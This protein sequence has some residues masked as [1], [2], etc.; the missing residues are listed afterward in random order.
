MIDSELRTI[1]ERVRRG[2]AVLSTK[3]YVD[4]DPANVMSVEEALDAIGN[5]TMQAME[6]VAAATDLKWARA[7]DRSVSP[8]GV[9]RSST[10][11]AVLDHQAR[12]RESSE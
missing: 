6:E 11:E 8:F 9:T 2:G 7:L 5:L 10:E 1:L 4:S 12:H 3:P